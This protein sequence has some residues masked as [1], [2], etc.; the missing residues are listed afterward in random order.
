[1]C[2]Q[3]GYAGKG[4]GKL[5]DI[6]K[7]ML[8]LD[9]LRGSH[10]TGVA[11]VQRSG[12]WTIIKDT[13]LP[14]DIIA[15]K[16]FEDCIKKTNMVLMGHNRWATK[17]AITAENA[18]PFQVGRIIGT[19][20][21]TLSGQWRLPDYKNFESDSHNLFH[22]IDKLGIK[23]AWKLVDGA[24]ACVWW[25]MEEGSLNMI[26]NGQRT[27]NFLI[28]EKQKHGGIDNNKGVFWASESWMITIAMTREGLEFEKPTMLKKDVLHKFTFASDMTITHT[29]EPL[30]PFVQ[31]SYRSV[32]VTR[33]YGS[34]GY[35]GSNQG[36]GTSTLPTGGRV[37]PFPKLSKRDKKALKRQE[38][39]EAKRRKAEEDGNVISWDGRL[40]GE[41]EFYSKYNR[42]VLCDTPLVFEEG[43]MHIIDDETA[44]CR[45]CSDTAKTWG[46]QIRCN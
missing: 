15:D 42:C 25:D 3:V 27:L 1:M 44:A 32:P 34:G 8:N 33:H 5:D 13:L 10:S 12:E 24:A 21:G 41:E 9:V 46:Q 28:P 22:A 35:G 2:G 20:N 45:G 16:E 40:L 23:E 43:G 14:P 30:I 37:I 19:H 7:V 29:E 26:T 6:F 18:H 39:Q 17:G 38:R 4:S 31:P 36:S 11:I